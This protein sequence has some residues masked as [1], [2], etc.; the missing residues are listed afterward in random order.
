MLDASLILKKTENSV[1]LRV[2]AKADLAANLRSAAPLIRGL[3]VSQ[4]FEAAALS[5]LF[6]PDLEGKTTEIW[7]GG[8]LI[9]ADHLASVVFPP[10][11]L[12]VTIT[13][14]K[15]QIKQAW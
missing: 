12:L 1:A 2:I 4:G 5:L 9:G 15:N 6:I 10:D 8:P 3:A 13:F 7:V 14:R 11:Y